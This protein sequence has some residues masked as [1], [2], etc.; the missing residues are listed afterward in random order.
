MAKSLKDKFEHWE[1]DKHS[2]NNAVIMLDSE[3]ESIESTKS[4][5]ARFESLKSDRPANKPKPKVNR[6]LV[7]NNGNYSYSFK[8]LLINLLLFGL[9]F[10][11]FFCF[12]RP[13][14]IC[15]RSDEKKTF[16]GT[17]FTNV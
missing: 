4:L 7:S 17:F 6:F 13:M 3:Q 11:L 9:S 5:R 2:L 10:F 1:P 15:R 8:T 12:C 16:I 14:L